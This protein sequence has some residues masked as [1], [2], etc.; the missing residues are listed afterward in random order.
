MSVDRGVVVADGM[1][2]ASPVRTMTTKALHGER[3]DNSLPQ[4]SRA[5]IRRCRR[6]LRQ[7][8]VL[9]AVTSPAGEVE[10]DAAGRCNT[11]AAWLKSIAAE[12]ATSVRSYVVTFRRMPSPRGRRSKNAYEALSRFRCR[13]RRL[14][15]QARQ[16]S[17]TCLWRI[18]LSRR[19]ARSRALALSCRDTGG[20]ALLSIVL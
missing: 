19:T 16:E 14:P 20:P 18:G 3:L 12:H 2:G 5:S 4:A 1:V 10:S 9:R 8:L 7:T 6:E 11:V 13:G 17:I 15:P